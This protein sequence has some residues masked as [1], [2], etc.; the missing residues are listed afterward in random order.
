MKDVKN[1]HVEKLL[2]FVILQRIKLESSLLVAVATKR[3]SNVLGRCL[4]ARDDVVCVF[5]QKIKIVK[6]EI[7]ARN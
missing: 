3:A 4:S 2:K 1:P 6:E 7:T 5:L